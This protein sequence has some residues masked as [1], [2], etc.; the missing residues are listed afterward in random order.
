MPPPMYTRGYTLL[1][2]P[3]GMP[4]MYTRGYATPCVTPVGML[5]PVLHPWV[6]LIP[7]YTPV[8]CSHPCLCTR[9]YLSSVLHPWVSLIGV[10]PGGYSSLP[11]GVVPS[12]QSVCLSSCPVRVN[13]SNAPL[14]PRL[15]FP[16]HCWVYSR[17]PCATVLSVP[18]LWSFS[19]CFPFHCWAVLENIPVSLLLVL[20]HRAAGWCTSL[21]Y[22]PISLMVGIFLI[23]PHLR[24]LPD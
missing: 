8:G 12:A 24:M 23:F 7:G 22:S 19:A 1:C 16:F 5:H 4:P 6:T 17:C 13:V 2:T 9:G 11:V 21:G 18:G 20:D 14:T 3:V 10:T 15:L